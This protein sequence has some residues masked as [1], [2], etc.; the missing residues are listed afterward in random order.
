MSGA[1][2]VNS[3]VNFD[4]S[5]ASVDDTSGGTIIGAAVTGLDGIKGWATF[6]VQNNGAVAADDF[7]NFIMEVKCHAT[8]QLLAL[9]SGTA[10][11]TDVSGQLRVVTSAGN[12]NTLG[13]GETAVV[14]V[15][16]GQVV[17]ILF[18]AQAASGKTLATVKVK[19]HA[20][21]S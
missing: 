3:V 21:R 4:L 2:A 12:L 11:N 15:R 10:W 18:R 8:G 14:D 6:E 1:L 19:G 16:I 7:Q 17:E 20:F 5:T 9:Y 13:D